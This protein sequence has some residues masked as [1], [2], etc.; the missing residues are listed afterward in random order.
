M[1]DLPG[2]DELKAAGLLDSRVPANFDV[3]EPHDGAELT[4]GEDPL[5]DADLLDGAKDGEPA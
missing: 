2:L 5:E 1:E 4:E 3:P